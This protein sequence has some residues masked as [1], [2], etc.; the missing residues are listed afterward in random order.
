MVRMPVPVVLNRLVVLGM[1]LRLSAHHADGDCL[2]Q[3]RTSGYRMDR[4]STGG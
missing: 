3:D 2:S 4:E 1:N